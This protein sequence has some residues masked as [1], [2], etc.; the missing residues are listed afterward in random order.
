MKRIMTITAVW[1]I[2][3][4][5]AVAATGCGDNPVAPKSIKLAS[6]QITT[7]SFLVQS[8]ATLPAGHLLFGVQS[9]PPSSGYPSPLILQDTPVTRAGQ[10]IIAPLVGPEAVIAQRLSDGADEV[11]FF[12]VAFDNGGGGGGFREPESTAIDSVYV[13]RSGPDLAGYAPTTVSVVVNE[14][15]LEKLNTDFW[16]IHFQTTLTIYGYRR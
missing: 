11:V 1:T 13:P 4:A 2:A 6:I 8:M 12:E 15:Y 16:Q 5:L 7:L 10:Q 14:F 9:D 3:I